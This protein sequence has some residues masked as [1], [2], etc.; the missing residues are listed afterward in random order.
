MEHSLEQTILSFLEG[1]SMV[2]AGAIGFIGVLIMCYGTLRGLVLFCAYT[3]QRSKLLIEIRMGIAKHLSLG[4]EFLV[5]KDIIETIV[6]P[7]LNRLLVLGGIVTLRMVI[8]YILSW[9]MRGAAAEI[10]QEE[11][12]ESALAQYARAHTGKQAS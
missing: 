3:R 2:A 1:T 7:T 6:S 4:L 11:D 10:R 9:E 5:G 12:I 8:A